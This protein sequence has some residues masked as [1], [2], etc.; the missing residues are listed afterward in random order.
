MPPKGYHDP[1]DTSYEMVVEWED[2]NLQT[3]EIHR[4]RLFYPAYDET[5]RFLN[6]VSHNPKYQLHR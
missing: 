3:S 4:K 6:S 2:F 5:V 1:A